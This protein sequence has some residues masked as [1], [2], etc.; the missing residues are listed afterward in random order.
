[1]KPLFTL[2][3]FLFSLTGCLRFFP[4]TTYQME[5]EPK[6]DS[7]P[8]SDVILTYSTE[9]KYEKNLFLMDSK[10]FYDEYARKIRLDYETQEIIEDLCDAREL[11]VDVVE[12]LTKRLN[13][14][15]NARGQM[16]QNHF[17]YQDYELYIKFTSF[18]VRFVDERDIG[19]ISLRNGSVTFYAGDTTHLSLPIWHSRTEP[20]EDS[21]HFV[22][23]MRAA[24]QHY[25]ET[26][27]EPTEESQYFKSYSHGAFEDSRY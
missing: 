22:T 9:L 21:R 7:Y 23:V 18:F 4:A 15:A 27:P 10:V 25:K 6:F 3:L 19:W 12:G 14:N 20:Y 5:P 1:M 11:I 2:L 26:H 24:E 8:F 16:A 13:E 17:D